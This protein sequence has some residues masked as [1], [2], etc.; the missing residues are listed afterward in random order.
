MSEFFAYWNEGFLGLLYTEKEKF[1][2]I[3]ARTRQKAY[4]KFFT[5]VFFL[6]SLLATSYQAHMSHSSA[7]K[8]TIK[9][10]SFSNGIILI[11]KN[12]ILVSLNYTHFHSSFF[13]KVKWIWFVLGWKMKWNNRSAWKTAMFLVKKI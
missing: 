4:Q 7:H 1:Y 10:R 3:S 13:H 11:R 6:F 5:F 9:A 12:C 8:F 2:G